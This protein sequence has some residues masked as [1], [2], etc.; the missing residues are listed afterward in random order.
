MKREHLY[1]KKETQRILRLYGPE[2]NPLT[3][4]LAPSRWT[5]IRH[6]LKLV[7]TFGL[8]LVYRKVVRARQPRVNEETVKELQAAV[9]ASAHSIDKGTGRK[10]MKN[11]EVLDSKVAQSLG[12]ARKSTV[13]EYVESIGVAVLIALLLRAFVVEAFKIPS[14]SMIPTLEVGDHIFVNKFSYGLRI[15]FTTNPP[16]RFIDWGKPKRGEVVVFINRRHVEH[17]FIKRVI[18]VGGDEVKVKDGTIYLRRRGRGSWKPVKKK[19]MSKECSYGDFEA[20][21]W[22][23][24]NDCDYYKEE[25]GGHR[26]VTVIDRNRENQ[27]YPPLELFKETSLPIGSLRVRSDKVFNPYRVPDGTVFVMGDNRTNSGDS[28]LPIKVGF[29]PREYIKGKALVVWSSWG[30]D[31]SWW[32]LRWHRIGHVIH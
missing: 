21:R 16:R 6:G 7:F 25:L 29:V 4:A 23:R 15:P 22:I 1:L 26:Y 32:G 10:A 8:W 28:R 13:R 9:E 14:G 3:G 12:F 18:A 5:G 24:Q 17:D 31:P 30:P 2:P 20:G 19:R 11:L 27:D